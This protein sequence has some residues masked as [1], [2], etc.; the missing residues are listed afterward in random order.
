MVVLCTRPQGSQVLG[1]VR[2]TDKCIHPTGTFVQESYHN[3]RSMT[4]MSTVFLWG[5]HVVYLP[6]RASSVPSLPASTL[7]LIY[8]LC[9][10]ALHAFLFFSA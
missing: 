9:V 7:W 2:R 6:V 8:H 4:T 5:G 10:P 1:K 3:A